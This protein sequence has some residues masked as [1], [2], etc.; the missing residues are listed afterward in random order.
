MRK[1]T[2]LACLSA[3]IVT[4]GNAVLL[5]SPAEATRTEK[6]CSSQQWAYAKGYADA[7]CGGPGTGSVTV[8]SSDEA[9]NLSFG[10]ACPM[11]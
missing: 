1:T 2:L 4:L 8:C 11:G 10:W 9:G 3:G 7:M 5:A 6:L